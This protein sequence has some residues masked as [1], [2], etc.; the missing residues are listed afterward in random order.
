MKIDNRPH[1]VVVGGGLSGLSASLEI[2]KLGGSVTI[3]ERTDTLGGRVKTDRVRGFLLDHGFQVLLTSYPELKRLHIQ[4][5]LH[6]KAFQSGA[7]CHRDH[8]TYRLINPFRHFTQFLRSIKEPPLI[9]YLD[10]LKLARILCSKTALTSSTDQLL[11]ER[12]ISFDTRH[13]FLEPFFGGVFLDTKLD[14]RAKIFVEYLRLFLSGLATLPEQGMQALPLAIH[15][16]LRNTKVLFNEEVKEIAEG[17][18][19]LA[20]GEEIHGDA[21][22]VA[23]DNPALGVWVE[24]FRD[25][26]SKSV[27]C[28]YYSVPQG[29][30]KKVPFLHLGNDSPVTNLCVPNHIQPSYAPKG[31]DLISATVIDPD[32]QK[33]NELEK[34]VKENV[35]SWLSIPEECLSLLKAYHIKHALPVQKAPPKLE[36]EIKMKG[37]KKV[38]LAGEMVQPPSINGALASGRKAGHAA[39]VAT[40]RAL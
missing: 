30:I 2:E 8:S 26:G 3:I 23:V 14:A 10:F 16:K 25:V 31:F 24:E 33:K 22:I 35:S 36:G 39:I 9:T 21:I 6:L 20:S 5:S 4:D 15:S 29:Q 17:H 32:W 38:F 13:Y 7:I 28:F 19:S 37:F 27:H 40:K 11:Q 12:G 34:F 18:V 1:I